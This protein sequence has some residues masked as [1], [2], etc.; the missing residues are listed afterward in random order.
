MNAA[1]FRSSDDSYSKN[2]ET[3]S[4]VTKS[5]PAQNANR[6][7]STMPLPT[8][9]AAITSAAAFTTTVGHASPNLLRSGERQSNR[10]A[11]ATPA[12]DRLCDSSILAQAFASSATP[13][14]TA[15]PAGISQ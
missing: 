5:A 2:R 11:A 13:I 8:H 10:E 12:A 1:D 14:A 7:S 3:M 6:R 4:V 15:K 9:T